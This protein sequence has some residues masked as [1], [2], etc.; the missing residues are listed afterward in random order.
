MSFQPEWAERRSHLPNLGEPSEGYFNQTG[1]LSQEF[2]NVAGESP[3][4]FKNYSDS[5][6]LS[7][8][9]ILK[10]IEEI[11]NYQPGLGVSNYLFTEG[12]KTAKCFQG[13]F[14]GVT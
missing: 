12:I 7:I 1:H 14:Q 2:Q 8:C 3:G 5:V 4:S 9:I 10:G 6:N 13:L 11:L